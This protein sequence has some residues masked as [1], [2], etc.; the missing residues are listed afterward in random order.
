MQE[1]FRLIQVYPACCDL[2]CAT[3]INDQNQ[4]IPSARLSWPMTKKA[5]LSDKI[6]ALFSIYQTRKKCIV[7]HSRM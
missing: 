1:L 4:L 7:S 5:I 3:T 2:R 6:V